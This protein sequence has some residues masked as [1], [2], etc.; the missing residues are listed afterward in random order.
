MK[1]PQKPSRSV[2]QNCPFVLS[3]SKDGQ[4]ALFDKLRANGGEDR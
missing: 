3:Q 2:G 4:E 1:K